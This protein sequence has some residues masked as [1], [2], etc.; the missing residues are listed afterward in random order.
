M[1]TTRSLRLLVV[2]GCVLGMLGTAAEAADATRRYRIEELEADFYIETRSEGVYK[3]IGLAAERV[4]NV[5][6]GRVKVSGYPFR[7]RCTG[8]SDGFNMSCSG[9][10]VSGW[11]VTRFEADPGMNSGL[12]VMKRKGRTIR[13]RFTGTSPYATT[14]DSYENSCGGTTTDVYTISRNATAEGR[15]LGRRVS[16]AGEPDGVRTAESMTTIDRTEECP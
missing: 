8:D 16:T 9:G 3:W 10:G 4:T 12:V 14:S 1:I 2:V 7:G 11:R 13:M 5:D 15:L 6:S